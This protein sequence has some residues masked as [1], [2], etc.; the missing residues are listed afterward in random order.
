MLILNAV[1]HGSVCSEC[2]KTL[3]QQA[4]NS[5]S[6]KDEKMVDDMND[7]HSH[8]RKD[9]QHHVNTFKQME[10]HHKTGLLSSST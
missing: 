10:Y 9:L 7:L 5:K 2:S 8:T 3:N 6:L 4:H 1:I